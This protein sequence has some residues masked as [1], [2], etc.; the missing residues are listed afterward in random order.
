MSLYETALGYIGYH[1]AG[2]LA[3]G[4]VPHGQ[5]TR[6]P[7][8]APYQVFPTRDGE[9]MIAGGN[10]RLFAAI[11]SVARPTRAR[12]RPPLPHEPRSGRAIA[13][14]SVRSWSAGGS[15]ANDT[16]HWQ[17]RL[18][19]AGVPAAPVADV[20]DVANAP[21]TEALGMIQPL[22]PPD[23]PRPPAHGAAALLRRRAGP[24]PVAAAARSVS[25]PPRSSRELGYDDDEIAAL[26]A[27]GVIRR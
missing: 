17:R 27:E 25:T 2:Y 8:V 4:T 9:L 23:D 21:Q 6:F 18:T 20:A 14:S 16:A 24:A 7:M 26:A 3:D 19:E 15:L 12:R 1:L 10:D 11:C 5:G 13:T 22:A